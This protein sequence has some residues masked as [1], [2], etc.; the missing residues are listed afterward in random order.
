MES[1][2]LLETEAAFRERVR[3]PPIE[4]EFTRHT[5]DS[6]LGKVWRPGSSDLGYGKTFEAGG[7]QLT[8]PATTLLASKFRV[9]RKLLSLPTESQLSPKPDGG[10]RFSW[11]RP[12]AILARCFLS[13]LHP[14][15]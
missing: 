12:E 13:Q 9:E 1:L 14:R 4:F 11:Q 3:F 8:A 2:L 15:I 7:P 5:I 10:V 6:A